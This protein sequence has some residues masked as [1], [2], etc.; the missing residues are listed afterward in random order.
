[1]MCHFCGNQPRQ[2][3][4]WIRL[5]EGENWICGGHHFRDAVQEAE[6][7]K[8]LRGFTWQ[9]TPQDM[10]LSQRRSW[11]TGTRRKC[12]LLNYSTENEAVREGV[13]FP[14]ESLA[15]TSKR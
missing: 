4:Y 2:D 14:A 15:C 11:S 5:G 10:R 12:E 7:R 6:R 3:P 1:M 13:L 8:A 9:S